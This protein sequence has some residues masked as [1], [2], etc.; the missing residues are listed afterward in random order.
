MNAAR[1][2]AQLAP[3]DAGIAPGQ[4]GAPGQGSAPG[5]AGA[6]GQ[7]RGQRAGRLLP[8]RLTAL[9]RMVQIA[10]ARSSHG[11]SGEL[12]ADAEALLGRAGE[13]LRLSP[14]HTVVALA[15]G[16]GSG[17]SSLFNRLAGA[18]FSTAGITRPVTTDPHACVWGVAGSGPLLEWLGVPR[19]YRYARASALD[20]GEEGLTGLVLVDLPDHDSV[21]AHASGE[22]DRIV[23]SADQI[24]WVLDPQKYADAAVHRRFLVPLAGHAEVIAVVLNQADLLTE[25]QTEDCIGDLRR[26]LD[27]EELHDVQ[28][29]VTSAATGAGLDDLRKLLMNAVSARQAAVARIS[30]D[31]DRM[32]ARFSPYSGDA[33]TGP[34]E[35]ATRVVAASEEQLAEA[36]GRAAGVTAVGDAL[37][38]ARELRAAD[39]VGWPVGWIY[40]RLRRRDPASKTRLGQLWDELRA[41][42][43]G[44]AGAQQAEIDKAITVVADEVSPGLPEPWSHTVRAALRSRSTDIPGGLGTVMGQSLPAENAVAGRWRAIGA[45]QGLLLGGVIVGL[46]W[47]AAIVVFG[48]FG[49]ASNVPHVFSNLA[50]LPWLAAMIAALLLIG[51]LTASACM[52]TVR[53]TAE[54]ESRQAADLMRQRMTDV[55]REMVIAPGEQELSELTRFREMYRVAIGRTA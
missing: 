21:L 50:L 25:A 14:A 20:R 47:F 24:I 41:V 54:L 9:A 53:A 49:V 33:D 28:I 22:V 48:G 12:L 10:A 55:A 5:Q 23:G 15:G 38:S 6:P 43:A 31:V 35:A 3:S 52:N 18:D 36:F 44:P 34:D 7:G 30:A 39:Y 42:T 4:S 32:A 2:A 51:A 16:T 13:R 27:A 19:R 26:L 45:W 46:A 37:R 11:V 17:K 29:L 40:R 1:P 8:E